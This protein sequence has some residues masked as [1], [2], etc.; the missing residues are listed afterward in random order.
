MKII[1]ENHW[2]YMKITN[3]LL[4]LVLLFN[5]SVKAGT[6]HVSVRSF[7]VVRDVVVCLELGNSN[8]YMCIFSSSG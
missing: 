4:S 2:G 1:N 8:K 5:N 3:F 7:K 6:L